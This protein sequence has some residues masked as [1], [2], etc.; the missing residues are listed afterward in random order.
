MQTDR[1][2]RRVF[3]CFVCAVLAVSFCEA[4]EALWPIHAPPLDEFQ[5]DWG[6]TPDA[7]WL[8]HVQM[9]C[10]KIAPKGAMAGASG[11]FV[12]PGGLVMTNRH[13]VVDELGKLSKA[14][15]NVARDGFCAMIRAEEIDC[16][17]LSIL[18]LSRVNEITKQ[19]Q[20]ALDKNP[21][22][23]QIAGLSQQIAAQARKEGAA[24]EV[25]S[26][27][28]GAQFWVYVYDVLDAKL[29]FAPDEA[30]G[31][32]GGEVDNFEFPRHSLDIAVLRAYRGGEPVRVTHF[33]PL[34]AKGAA[35]G[36]PVFLAGHPGE[37]Q[38]YLPA[39]Q[40]EFLRDYYLPARVAAARECS[41]ALEAFMKTSDDARK[42]A[43]GTFSQWANQYKLFTG[44][45]D[46]LKTSDFITQRS[47]LEQEWQK[48]IAASEN[49]R[50]LAGDAFKTVLDAIAVLKPKDISRHFSGMPG[51][52]FFSLARSL[53]NFSR[54][55]RGQPEA[56]VQAQARMFADFVARVSQPRGVINLDVERVVLTGWLTAA[57]SLLPKDDPFLAIALK[58]KTPA[59]A[60]ERIFQDAGP[61]ADAERII[62]MVSRGSDGIDGAKIPLLEFLKEL[63]ALNAKNEDSRTW[64]DR[65]DAAL[66]A[67]QRALFSV[68]GKSLAPDACSSLRL[69]WG[70][71]SGYTEGA[72]SIP[73]RTTFQTMLDRSTA[74]QGKAPFELSARFSQA[75]AK[76]DLATPLDFVCTADGAPGCSGA[77]LFNK[78]TQLLG[79]LFDGNR[80]E[81]PSLYG[82]MRPETGG[83][84]IGVHVAAIWAGL[85]HIY[86]AT[87]LV[88]ELRAAAKPPEK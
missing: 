79:L 82:Y 85:E 43:L 37:T 58:G 81:V 74:M 21:T 62:A 86:E 11:V 47:K 87:S 27:F 63:E 2:I 26:F 61:L 36:D 72:A 57:Q 9:S 22:R 14:G 10:V 54:G 24:A 15:R 13:V 35:D 17:E 60:A 56:R 64:D 38:R 46:F 28:G 44:N 8:T 52:R 19:A 51:G 45:L 40:L 49:A 77:P 50:E 83:R 76:F 4:G 73:W 80:H 88:E 66:L 30:L 23:A 70:R 39:T 42:N 25:V 48:N 84:S 18:V 5:K 65:R 20:A 75:K 34:S 7:V 69:G 33:M 3:Q 59:E 68:Q 32:F 6:F 29:V 71:V 53:N 41:T 78:E 1:I 31:R 16:P 12:S 55:A 67:I